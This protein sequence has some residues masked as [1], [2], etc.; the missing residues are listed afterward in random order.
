VSSGIREHIQA[1]AEAVR[2]RP[3]G[4]AVLV[5]GHSNTIP[6]IVGALGGSTLPDLKDENYSTVYI[7]TIAPG[8]DT[9]TIVTHF[10]E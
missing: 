2:T 5:V 9:R 8:I 10:I 3:D 7:L 4:D 1:V 6:A